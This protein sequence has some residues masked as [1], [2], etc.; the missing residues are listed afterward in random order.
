[1]EALLPGTKKWFDLTLW[2]MIKDAPPSREKLKLAISLSRPKIAQQVVPD[3]P[4]VRRSPLFDYRT[5]A[6]L[7][8]QG[9]VDALTTLFGAVREAE[10]RMDKAQ[11]VESIVACLHVVV[12]LMTEP[13]FSYARD[14]LFSHLS[15]RFFRRIVDYPPVVLERLGNADDCAEALKQS[16][17][18]AE[19]FGLIKKTRRDRAYFAYCLY[20]KGLIKNAVSVFSFSTTP[21]VVITQLEKMLKGRKRVV[22]AGS[23]IWFSSRFRSRDAAMSRHEINLLVETPGDNQHWYP[24]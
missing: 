3:G 12:V 20:R 23:S 4:D 1:V 18:E 15:H 13:P 10:L 8:I 22:P 6:S 16:L 14:A 19:Q 17:S 5:I 24:D 9:D 7:W 2:D 21:D 11:F